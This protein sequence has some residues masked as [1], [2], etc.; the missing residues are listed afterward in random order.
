MG[1]RKDRPAYLLLFAIL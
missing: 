1:V